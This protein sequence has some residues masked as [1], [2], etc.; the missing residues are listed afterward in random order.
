MN[1][2]VKKQMNILMNDKITL[3]QDLFDFSEMTQKAISFINE[4]LDD[5]V[6][7]YL[8]SKGFRPKKTKEYIKSLGY[9]LKR[10]GLYLLIE[11]YMSTNEEFVYSFGYTICLMP[12]IEPPKGNTIKVKPFKGVFINESKSDI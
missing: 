5:E 7:K 4:N 11:P 9:R 12:I 1:E 3:H 8:K 2:S 10:K 6:I